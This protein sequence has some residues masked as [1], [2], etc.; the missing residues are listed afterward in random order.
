MIHEAIKAWR[1]TEKQHCNI[2]ETSFTLKNKVWWPLKIPCVLLRLQYYSNY[3]TRSH[4]TFHRDPCQKFLNDEGVVVKY[5]KALSQYTDNLYT[6]T[7]NYWLWV[8]VLEVLGISKAMENMLSAHVCVR[9][10][11]TT[12]TTTISPIVYRTV[13]V[14]RQPD[15]INTCS[16]IEELAIGITSQWQLVY[17]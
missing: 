5:M 6:R 10:V 3:R 7:N 1:F 11:W 14:A 9:Y 4:S 2:I 13:L 8:S 16:H 17:P 12:Y 15:I